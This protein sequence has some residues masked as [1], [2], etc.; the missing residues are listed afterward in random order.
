M[1]SLEQVEQALA[2]HAPVDLPDDL[3]PQRAAVAALLRR[4]TVGLEV[5]LMRR[6]EHPGD[7]WSGQIALPGGRRQG[8]DANLLA[9]AIRETREE[10]GRH[11][12]RS[13]RLLGRLGDVRARAR[14]GLLPLAIRPFVFAETAPEPVVLG[15]EAA[16][17]LWLPVEAALSG[18]LDSLYEY[19][20]DVDG[21]PARFP[22]WRHDG[23][24]VWGLT[25][26]ILSSLLDLVADEAP[27]AAAA[28][29]CD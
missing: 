14:G 21:A 24:V 15:H 18:E 10:V 28:A 2:R 26:R 16:V 6:V 11:L 25:Y 1:V 12:D 20:L 17:A 29:S 23:H 3:T 8:G 22:C 19:P 4:R 9:T 7:R 27:C 13:A 5:L